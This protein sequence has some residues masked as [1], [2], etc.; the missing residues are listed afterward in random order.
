MRRV[1]TELDMQAQLRSLARE[2][3]AGIAESDPAH[4]RELL[5]AFVS[6]LVLAVADQSQREE[7]RQK[8]AEGIAVAKAKGV[9]FGRPAKPL[10]DN[11]DEM[12]QAWRNGQMTLGQA[13]NA[14]GM[15]ESSFYNAAVREKGQ[16]NAPCGRAR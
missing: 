13:A 1:S 11:F 7:R 14:C 12:H 5:S 16:K 2:V 10:P 4:S 6:E 3:A 8:Q 15:P 9:R